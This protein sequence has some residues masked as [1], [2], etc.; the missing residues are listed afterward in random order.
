MFR[1]CSNKVSPKTNIR[2]KG[3]RYIEVFLREFDDDSAGSIKVCPL[4]PG[5]R[6]IACLLKTRLT[7][8]LR[9]QS[10]RKKNLL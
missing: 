1:R 2:Y 4:L 9:N 5:V 10:V 8:L 3:A 7:V 6:Y